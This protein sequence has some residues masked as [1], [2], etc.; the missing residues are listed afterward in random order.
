MGCGATAGC[1]LHAGCAGCDL[2]R[3]HGAAVVVCGCCWLLRLRAVIQGLLL[4]AAE[5]LWAAIG[6]LPSCEIFRLRL[7]ATVEVSGRC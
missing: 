3:L 7:A 5:R 1:L 6:D 2:L 4:G